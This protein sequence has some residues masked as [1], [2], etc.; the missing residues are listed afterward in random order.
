[1]SL[2]VAVP[3]L[4]RP[5]CEGQRTQNHECRDDKHITREHRQSRSIVRG[6]IA[7]TPTTYPVLVMAMLPFC[8][9]RDKAV[10]GV[11]SRP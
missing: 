6:A 11:K 8:K 5:P 7:T 2:N 3:S 1:M 10:F 4:E 9:Q